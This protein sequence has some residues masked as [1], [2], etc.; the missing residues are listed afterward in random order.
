MKLVR[1]GLGDHADHGCGIAPKLCA[2]VVGLDIVLAHRIRV[3]NLVA[4]VAQAGHV[5]TA[6]EIVRN[7]AGKVV[8][9]AV[10]V[11]VIFN[12]SKAV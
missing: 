9:G 3:W 1:S 6:I 5:E 11:D 7:L 2:E 8:R 10:D 12:E 4:A